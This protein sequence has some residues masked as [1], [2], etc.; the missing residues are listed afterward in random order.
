MSIG[1]QLR[2]GVIGM[3]P[4]GSILAAHLID[5]GAFVVPC[6]ID[7][8]RIDSIKRAGILLQHTIQMEVEVSEACYTARELEGFDLNLVAIAVKTPDLERVVE[9]L[10]ESIL[11]TAFVVCA[12]NGLDNEL[13]VARVLGVDRILRMVVN[14][15]GSITDPPAVHVSFF[16]PPNYVAAMT[17]QGKPVAAKLAGVL[18]SSGLKTEVP[19]HIRDH[20]WKKVI[21]NAALAPLC[22]IACKTMKEVVDSHHGFELV[23]AIIDESIHVAEAEGIALGKDFRSFC[24]QYLQGGGHHRPSMLVDLENGRQTEI[25]HMNGKIAEYGRKHGLPTPINWS[26]TSLVH[27]LERIE[28]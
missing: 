17:P 4:V 21:L 7:H 9:Q 23:E 8:Q 1:D 10:P 15:A 14:Y 24:I 12:Q 13:E 28:R 22:T 20:I 18:N 11:D 19:D 25:D 27:M 6:D 16:N 26:V 5:A 3:G 2:I